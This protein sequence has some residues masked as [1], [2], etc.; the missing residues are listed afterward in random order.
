MGCYPFTFF[1]NNTYPRLHC[2]EYMSRLW[3]L[4]LIKFKYNTTKQKQRRWIKC[5]PVN[6]FDHANTKHECG[7]L[8]Y[9]LQTK[10]EWVYQEGLDDAELDIVI[11]VCGCGIYMWACENVKRRR[12]YPINLFGECGRVLLR[13]ATLVCLIAQKPSL[14]WFRLIKITH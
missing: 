8:L 2:N 1:S 4:K 7:S 9:I 13:N 12:K 3:S 10:H 14:G 11:W 6:N 5:H